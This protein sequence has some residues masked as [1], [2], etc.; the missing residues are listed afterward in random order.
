[1][2]NASHSQTRETKKKN[3]KESYQV[4]DKEKIKRLNDTLGVKEISWA[5]KIRSV[6]AVGSGS[7]MV[8]V[9]GELSS[10]IEL[11]KKNSLADRDGSKHW[12]EW[13]RVPRIRSPQLRHAFP[14]FLFAAA[15][16]KHVHLVEAEAAV[17]EE[18]VFF[19]PP[20]GE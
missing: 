11:L 13:C 10:Y 8:A 7:T 3:G 18:F 1:M 14:N 4:T 6:E 20:V 15:G 16:E 19:L 2:I 5:M 17:E 12:H 9:V